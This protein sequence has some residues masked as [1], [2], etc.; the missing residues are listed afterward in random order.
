MYTLKEII[1]IQIGVNQRWAKL[2]TEESA[3]PLKTLFQTYRR[4]QATIATTAAPLVN[5]YFDFESIRAGH[6]LSNDTFAQFLTAN[7]NASLT[8][9]AQGITINP[10]TARY[11]DIWR[12]GFKLLAVNDANDG[13]NQ[14][15]T[16]DKKHIRLT[17]AAPAT[18]YWH[19]HKHFMVSVNGFYHLTD[20]DGNGLMVLDAEHT[21]RLSKS[22][23]M[24]ILSFREIGELQFVPIT[25]SMILFDNPKQ[26]VLTLSQDLTN[27]TVMLVIGGYLHPVDASVYQRIGEKS[28]RLDFDKI[29]LLER[30][31]ESKDFIDLSSLGLHHS[32]VND[33]IIN[34]DEF[35]SDEVLSAW[36]KLSQTFFVIVDTPNLYTQR[37]YIRATR[38][39][40]TYTSY[41]EPLYPLV[42]DLGR[43]PEYWSVF[44]DQQWAINT[45][46]TVIERKLFN[47]TRREDL[48]NVDGK[49]VP[50]YSAIIPSAYLLE[51][52][53]DI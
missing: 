47:T 10:K 13:S 30:Y 5:L 35:Y 37:Q 21:R 49:R 29:P 17:R 26:A 31:F 52:G 32:N 24:G 3:L 6:S 15:A 50:H 22:A 27:K 36:L 39:P 25:N 28:F 53:K 43:Q 34:I 1:G 45:Y 41:K 7:G 51:I 16:E 8:T 14:L 4:L 38:A 2:T 9:T 44:E 18:D 40:D 12:L 11:S 33:E 19:A 20:T 23:H 46:R 48:V 42:T